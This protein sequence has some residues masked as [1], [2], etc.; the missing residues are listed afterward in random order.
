[1]SNETQIKKLTESCR[2]KE[3]QKNLLTFTQRISW[4]KTNTQTKQK[5][6]TWKNSFYGHSKISAPKINRKLPFQGNSKEFAQ[7]HT[8]N[9]LGRKKQTHKENKNKTH[10]KTWFMG[11]PGHH[12]QKS[13]RNSAQ[14]RL[15]PLQQRLH[16]WSK[17]PS[18]SVQW[19][20]IYYLA[21]NT[22]LDTR[23]RADVGIYLQSQIS[24]DLIWRKKRRVSTFFKVFSKKFQ[25]EK[26]LTINFRVYN[27]S[28]SCVTLSSVN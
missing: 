15:S 23:L 9:V 12:P 3:T 6:D 19:K 26:H 1:M 16:Y 28:S 8:K 10:E 22:N 20:I 18:P 27:Q 25:F 5:Q 2:F 14:T 21:V 13:S 24:S 4:P 17:Y 11:A 7:F